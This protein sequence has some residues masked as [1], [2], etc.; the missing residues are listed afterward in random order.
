MC[1]NLLHTA[2]PFLF[3]VHGRKSNLGSFVLPGCGACICLYY[4]EIAPKFWQIL[5]YL[6]SRNHHF[7]KIRCGIFL[8]EPIHKLDEHWMAVFWDWSLPSLP[9][10]CLRSSYIYCWWR[11]RVWPFWHWDSTGEFPIFLNIN[12][13]DLAVVG[14]PVVSVLLIFPLPWHG[15]RIQK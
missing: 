2:H 7:F 14:W 6:V 4:P 11:V 15:D 9:L 13:A 10:W 5:H 12:P 3:I 8:Q 1:I